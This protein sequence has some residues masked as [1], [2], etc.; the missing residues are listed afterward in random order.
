MANA[1]VF[2]RADDARVERLFFVALGVLGG[3]LALGFAATPFVVHAGNP[4]YVLTLLTDD[5]YYYAR[6]ARNTLAGE[7]LSFDGRTP[8]NGFHPLWLLTLLALGAIVGTGFALLAGVYAIAAAMSLWA[9]AETYRLLRVSGLSPLLSAFGAFFLQVAYLLLARGGM[10]VIV[11]IPL[12]LYALRRSAIWVDQPSFRRACGASF[13]ASLAI[14]ARLDLA[15]LFAILGAASAIEAG[16]DG[17][18]RA[19]IG[20]PSTWAA[21]ALGLLPIVIWAATGVAL[22]GAATPVS[23]AAKQLVSFP[24]LSWGFVADAMSFSR[25]GGLFDFLAGVLMWSWLAAALLG[26]WPREGR[27]GARIAGRATMLF[28][29]VFYF[30]VG[31]LSAWHLW[32]WYFYPLVL[33]APFMFALVA[34]AVGR[35]TATPRLSAIVLCAAAFGVLIFAVAA[36]ILGAWRDGSQYGRVRL[37]LAQDFAEFAAR[38]PGRYAIGDLAGMAAY[39]TTNPVVQLEGLVGDRALLERIKH[40]DGLDVVLRDLRIDY[41]VVF[42]ILERDGA[43]Y[44]VSEPKIGQAGHGSPRMTTRICAPPIHVGRLNGREVVFVFQV[45]S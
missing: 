15:L 8:T 25:G 20:R 45:A 1:P 31:L 16:R 21:A 35:L 10:E 19:A 17:S 13:A 28:V 12:A 30:A 44:D 41:Y 38:H 6:I 9:G 26:R 22:T 27:R 5:F 29:P 24:A 4:D 14:L 43:C 7:F 40:G 23:S 37:A 32:P 3:A 11:A 39:L 18:L 42:G 2:D 33:A 36:D 34:E